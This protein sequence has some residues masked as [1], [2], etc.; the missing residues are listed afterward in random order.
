[1]I[2]NTIIPGL[3]IIIKQSI[4][5]RFKYLRFGL[6]TSP[7][8]FV[9]ALDV[10]HVLD[11]WEVVLFLRWPEHWWDL[12]GI[13]LWSLIYVLVSRHQLDQLSFFIVSELLHILIVGCGNIVH[14][15]CSLI[16]K[17][18]RQHLIFAVVSEVFVSICWTGQTSRNWSSLLF[19]SCIFKIIC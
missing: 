19:I 14:W 16:L 8:L 17:I 13:N 4:F 10:W 12:L 18:S 5:F 1:M 11:R 9:I 2:R 3:E 6:Q 7:S 15:S